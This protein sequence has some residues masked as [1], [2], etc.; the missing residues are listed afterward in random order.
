M[1]PRRA[2]EVLSVAMIEAYARMFADPELSRVWIGEEPS[3][4]KEESRA[5][6]NPPVSPTELL[7]EIRGL[8]KSGA[9]R[10]AVAEHVRRRRL[11]APLSVVDI[12]DWTRA[13]IPRALLGIA[14][15]C[16]VL[17]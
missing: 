4:S 13:G 15:S 6:R 8:Q 10:E 2:N 17:E 16:E 14:L 3:A 11:S 12:A 7:E 1:S 5:A 9:D